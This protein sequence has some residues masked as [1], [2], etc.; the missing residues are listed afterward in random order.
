[1]NALE[2]LL[3]PVADIVNRQIRM[4]TRARELCDALEGRVVAV[5]LRGS[6]LALYFVVE[7]DGIHPTGRFDGEPDVVISGSLLSLARLPGRSGEAAVRD[8]SLDLGGDADVARMFQQLLMY[9]RPDLEEELSAI[10]GDSAAH[11]LGG[12]ARGL[13]EWGRQA[14]S[15]LRQNL[16]EYLQEESRAVPSRLETQAFRRDV[17]TLRDDVER[18]EARLKRLESD[19]A[20]R[21]DD[22]GR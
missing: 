20:A 1:M 4:K 6:A 14:G 21:A 2:S 12:L 8:G 5:R 22:P 3:R 9:G 18:L 13:G 15:T 11:G 7:A 19:A 17:E 10:V 16:A